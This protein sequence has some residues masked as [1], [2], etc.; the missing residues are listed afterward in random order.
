M[1][2]DI[3]S[4]SAVVKELSAFLPDSL[5][6]VSKLASRVKEVIK[7]HV[8]LETYF[9]KKNFE[10]VSEF[11]FSYWNSIS[12]LFQ[13]SHLAKEK[14]NIKEQFVIFFFFYW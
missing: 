1:E 5:I 8:S 6:P 11:I 7:D 3:S 12:N 4:E 9:V 2:A 14:K 10:K 13:I